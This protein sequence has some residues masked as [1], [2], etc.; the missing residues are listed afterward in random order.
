MEKNYTTTEGRKSLL[1]HPARACNYTSTLGNVNRLRLY[2]N[3]YL[4]F[5]RIIKNINI[6]EKKVEPEKRIKSSTKKRRA[7]NKCSPIKP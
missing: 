6:E 4:N 2:P 7:E 1:T 3:E 5:Q